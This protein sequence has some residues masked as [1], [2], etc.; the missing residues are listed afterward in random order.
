MNN[1]SVIV[2][3]E[4][5]Q[6]RLLGTLNDHEI[7]KTALPGLTNSDEGAR[8]MLLEG[9]TREPEERRSAVRVA[10]NLAG[11]S[12][13]AT[14]EALVETPMLYDAVGI[15]VRDRRQRARQ[16]TVGVASLRDLQSSQGRCCK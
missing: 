15:A 9:L 8:P 5:R 3:P 2:V 10:D 14:S 13:A 12:C 16:R 4:A 6:T 1:V 11:S 7:F